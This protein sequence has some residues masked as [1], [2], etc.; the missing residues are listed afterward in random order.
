M[1]HWGEPDDEPLPVWMNPQTYHNGNQM[2]KSRQSLEEACA[3][4]LTKPAVPVIIQEPRIN[5]E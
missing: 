2:K 3:T 1:N 4:A 5:D